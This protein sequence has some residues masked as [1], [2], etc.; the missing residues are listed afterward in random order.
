MKKTRPLTLALILLPLM[1][2][3]E[4]QIRTYETAKDPAARQL[5]TEG[6][7]A[8]SSDFTA[9]SAADGGGAS[10]LVWQLPDGWTESPDARPMRLATFIAPHPTP[11][12][13][14]GDKTIDEASENN[15]PAG[16][17]HLEIA[18]S[19]FPDDVGGPLAN[20]NRWRAQLGLD[21]VVQADLAQHF[22][23]LHG[24]DR[25]AGVLATLDGRAPHADLGETDVRMLVAMVPDA[26]RTW[27]LKAVGLP[28]QVAVHRESF[29]EFAR[30]LPPTPSTTA[31]DRRPPTVKAQG[32]SP[33]ASGGHA[34]GQTHWN[35][36]PHWQ[37]EADASSMLKGAYLAPNAQGQTDP[38]TSARIT[39][40]TLP[41][42]GGG[43]LPNINR[44]RAQLGLPALQ[45]L[46]DQ[47]VTRLTVG[48]HPGA[49]LDLVGTPPAAPD[50]APPGMPSLAAP[51]DG[52]SVR[53]LVTLVALPTETWFIKMSGPD[54]AVQ[55]Q[56]Q[57][58]QNLLDSIHFH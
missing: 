45:T 26:G 34:A 7:L 33:A 50:N 20:L 12:D 4:E 30:T 22:E 47:P 16:D 38:A 43:A 56:R 19:A 39:L 48:G 53:T 55:A 24:E 46:D 52:Q 18:L 14:A 35:A 9:A 41:G 23:P 17:E 42:D 2:C 49:L 54:A 36:P 8:A 44:W 57:A 11:A 1:A 5:Q 29:L 6:P 25:N 15:T 51:A 21:P 31:S 40:M 10:G 58:F 28:Q 32:P 13:E 27:F 3:E 37:P